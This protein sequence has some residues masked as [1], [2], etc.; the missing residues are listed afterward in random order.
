MIDGIGRHEHF[1][2]PQCLPAFTNTS[3][4]SMDF[5]FLYLLAVVIVSSAMSCTSESL[6]NGE[7]GRSFSTESGRSSTKNLVPIIRT[8]RILP[9]SITLDEQIFAQTDSFDPDADLVTYRHRW[10]VNGAIVPG[11][12]H[13]TFNTKALK[14]GD[15]LTVEV[16]PY[17]GNMEG[18][19]VGADALVANTPPQVTEFVFEPSEVRVGDRIRLQVTGSDADQ[20][21]VEYRYRWWRNNSEVA[22]GDMSELD[23]NGFLKGDTVI[24]E[25]TPSD[26]TTKGK[27]KLSNPITILNSPPRITTVPPAKIERGRF[28][29]V[30]SA[31]D[32]DG[33]QLTYALEVAPP[34][35]KIDK[36]TGRIEWLLTSKLAGN[37][38]VRV[39]ATDDEQAKAFQEFDLTFAAP[40]NSSR[41]GFSK[42][43][44]LNTRLV[45]PFA[46][47]LE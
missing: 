35:M 8:V 25:V 33:D 31:K 47:L 45:T 40:M 18:V 7:A 30:A 17:D 41:L 20:D 9:P 2:L 10:S 6:Q 21:M 28:V 42:N 12:T 32:P 24:V 43:F 22:D 4:A 34:G 16:T 29:Y 36:V 26:P 38:K 3:K 15:R 39:T 37:Y 14:R 11:E 23:T 46:A 1:R 19:P 13:S 5:K 27:S 44:R